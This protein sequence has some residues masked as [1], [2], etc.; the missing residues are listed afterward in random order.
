MLK[1]TN[2]VSA[3]LKMLTE[4]VLESNRPLVSPLLAIGIACRLPI[5]LMFG[6]F[7]SYA[8][9]FITFKFPEDDFFSQVDPYFHYLGGYMAAAA[10]M[11]LF[12]VFI[13]GG[14]YGISLAYLSIPEEKREKSM[15][16]SSLRGTFKKLC[17]FGITINF[18]IACISLRYEL[19]LYVAPLIFISTVVVIQNII[20]SEIFRYGLGPLYNKLSQ[21][22]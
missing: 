10:L 12:G 2:D 19:I 1:T 14:L 13:T 8:W 4:G 17:L 15:V 5:F 3:D 11:I 9:L 7:F 20:G 22:K 16:V 21:F 18:F 6:Y